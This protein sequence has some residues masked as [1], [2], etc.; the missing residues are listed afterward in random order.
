M[1]PDTKTRHIP[2]G[3]L[4]TPQLQ[5]ALT[6]L[7]GVEAP[8]NAVLH[9]WIKS[10]LVQPRLDRTNGRAGWWTMDDLAFIRLIVRLRRSGISGQRVRLILS[11]IGSELADLLH[12]DTPAEL[13]VNGYRA[14]LR[15]PGRADREFPGGQLRL[16]LASVI[17][18]NDRVAAAVRAA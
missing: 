8:S 1:N 18:N 9:S 11:Q 10:G 4:T 13:I 3:A 7:E 15:K 14:V 6:R 5:E 12:T 2:A 16:P 17:D